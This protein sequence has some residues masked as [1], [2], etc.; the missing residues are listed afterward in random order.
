MSVLNSGIRENLSTTSVTLPIEDDHSPLLA[1]VV[2]IFVAYLTYPVIPPYLPP[3]GNEDTIFDPGI[4]INHFY[5]C[6][7][8]LS[9]RHGAFKKF[10]THCSHL[11]EWRMIINEKNTPLLDVLLLLPK[12]SILQVLI[13]SASI[14]NHEKS[15]DSFS[16]LGF[17]AFQPST[18]CPMIIN[19][20]NT[21]VS[22]NMTITRSGM[23]LEAI[24]ELVNRLVEEAFAAYE[25]T[26]AANALEL[27]TKAKRVV[28]T[29]MEMG[30]MEMGTEGVVGLIRW[31]EKMETV[32]HIS[33]CQVKYQVKYAT[34]TLLS[35][36]LTRMESELWNL[37]AKNNDLS[38]Y[39]KRFQELT[40]MCTKMVPEEEDQVER[41]IGGLLD[42][43]QR[44][45]IVVEPT[46][47]QDAICIANN[48]IDQKLKGILILK[49]LVLTT[50]RALVENKRVP[51]CFECGRQG[52]YSNECLK[53][54]NQNHGNK[55]GKKTKEA[56]GKAYVLGGGEANLDSN[57]VTGTF[58]LNNHYASMIFDSGADRSFVSSTFSTLLDITPDTL[59]VSYAV[60]LADETI[61]ESNTILKGY[62]LGVLGHPFNIDLMPVELGSFDV[63]ISMDWLTNHHVK[64]TKDK[65]EEKRLED[66]ETGQREL[67]ARVLIAGGE[68]ASL[69]E[70]VASLERSNPRIRGIVM[71]ESVRADRDIRC[72]AF[73]Y[74]SMM[75]C[76]H[77][78]LVNITI[79]R[80]GMTLEAIKELVNRRV[81]EAF[82]AY[83]ATRVA[84]ALEAENQRQNGS[85]NDNGNGR[86]GNG[87]N[88][89]GENVNGEN[90]NGNER[91]CW[92]DKVVCEDGNSVPYQQLS[93]KI[94]SQ[95]C[96]L[97]L[98]E[99]CINLLNSHKR[100]VRT[101]AAFP[102][103]WRELIE[104]MAEVYCPINEI[105]RM[106]SELWNLTV[107][108]F[109]GG[110]LDNIQG[111]V[112]VVE[113]TRLQ[114]VVCITNNLMDQKLKGY[115]V[116]NAENKRRFEVN[117]RDNR[118]QQPPCKRQNVGG[119]NVVRAYT[120]GN[121]EK[122]GYD[123]PLPYCSKCKLHHEGP[124]TMKC[125]KCNKVGHMARHCKNAVVVPT[126]V[127][128]TIPIRSY[129][130]DLAKTKMILG[131]IL[132]LKTLVLTTQRALV[133]NHRVLTCFECGRQGHYRNECPKLK[134]QNCGNKA[135]KRIEEA[136]G[137]AY[138]LGGGEA[139]LDSNVVM[140]TFLLNN[141]DASMIFDSGT[142]RSFVSSTFSTLLNITPDTLDVSYAVEL[143]NGRISE[144]N[145][146]LRGCTLGLLGHPFI[147]DLMPLELGSFDVIIGMDWLGNHHAVIVCDEK[148]IRICYEDEVL[149]VQGDGSDEGKKSKLSI[150]S[151]TKTQ[152]YI[153]RGAAPVAYAPYRLAPTELQELS[154]QVQE[155]S[156]KG[157]REEYIP[158]TSFRTRYGQYEFQVI[159]F[160]LP[161]AP[162]ETLSEGN[163]DALHLGPERPRVYSDLSPEE[164]ERVDRIEVKGTMHEVQVQLVM[165]E[166]RTELGMQ[167]HVKQGRLSA[168]TATAPTA[169]TM[170]MANLSSADLVYDEAGMSYDSDILSEVHD[171]DYYQDAV[172]EHH[173]YVKD[174]TMPVVQSNVC[175]VPNDAYMI[176][177]NDMH[178]QHA[179]HVSV[180]THNNVIDKSLT[181]KLATYKEQVKLKHD[182]IE[183]EN[184]LIANDKLIVDC[185]SKDVFY[186]ATDY[187][188][189]VSRFFDMHE[190]LNAAQKRI[191]KLEYE[192]SNL[193]NKIQNDDHDVMVKHF[194][195]LEVEHLNLQLKYQHL[196]ES[197]ENKKLVTSSDAPTFDL[198]FVIG[199]LKDHVQSRGNTIQELREKISRLTK[200]HSDADPI[201]DLKVLDSQNKE[202][203]TKINALHDLIEHWQAENE[204]VK[205][206]YKELYDLIKITCAKTIDNTNSLLTEV[207]N[208]K[209]QITEN[210]KLNCVTMPVVKSKV[211][212]PG[213]YIIDVELIIPC[214][215]NNKEVYL[216][217]LKHIKESVA[218]LYEI[219][220][221]YHQ[222]EKI[223]AK[224]NK[225]KHEM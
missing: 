130:L 154:S 58:L 100:T 134:N 66:V 92:V 128:L 96:Y 189:T 225:T 139:N 149:I 175:S 197:F 124:C 60:K 210:H 160:G 10:N 198:V 181:V 212:A 97:H 199:Q 36:A 200:K 172:C 68:G 7:P 105:Q 108:R 121:N 168:T 43:I 1:Y 217:Y 38:A 24:E 80:F 76:V 112:I 15:P 62:T 213:M 120:A 206:H 125:K 174:N 158:K 61:S 193:Q 46:R 44:N 166:L 28:T 104:L 183:Q 136:R 156:D 152:K 33:N 171:H 101:E 177:L 214:N 192:N 41:F 106:E 113:P 119:Q 185:L 17:E 194:S 195:K 31:F 75:L 37:T 110:L 29:I 67:E 82:A 157:L 88:I 42:N 202:L 107:K 83:E 77:F 26:R 16:H 218:I 19:G 102:V 22:D 18:E 224:P 103:S 70:K 53:L 59:D 129:D 117:Q 14:G 162:E 50:Q 74:S 190:A 178:E 98:V 145:T 143:A 72:E 71:M 222:K 141:H 205:R 6:E 25:A 89:N 9:H 2:W 20:K 182:E 188:L 153:K 35:I 137:K 140:G 81:E 144:T 170:F 5:S 54:K 184:L 122:I 64:K 215:K 51:T 164:K 161:N 151:C 159:P 57:V 109:I 180:T 114:D 204:K 169:Q 39:I 127:D 187:L 99:Q 27:K 150:I 146:V 201:H 123:G 69:L 34:C 167:I 165:G 223:Q 95:V 21:P 45:V 32:F 186:T 209:A 11:N 155:L 13:S 84:N 111:N 52:H 163:E 132:I 23:T 126:M 12:D 176:I 8:V 135:G 191:A 86:N 116:K 216:D 207:A 47:L 65:S 115:P 203:H 85:E 138:M 221:G 90:R 93:S 211:L 87:G 179:Q 131:R 196:K 3:F 142:D 63:I 118:G 91:S 219:G 73:G 30:G 220:N 208:L 94:S 56:R 148:I 40:M 49:T 173:E 133:V 48:L 78:R 55:S 79:T 4:I 147:I